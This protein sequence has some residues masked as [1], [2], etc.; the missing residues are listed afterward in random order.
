MFSARSSS[1][2]TPRQVATLTNSI[3]TP[4]PYGD[5]SK[6]LYRANGLIKHHLSFCS[7]RC[8]P[9]EVE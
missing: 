2:V 7:T 4:Q 6:G 1:Q 3:M 9:H 5:S 8:Q